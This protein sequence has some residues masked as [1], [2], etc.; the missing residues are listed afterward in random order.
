MA[1]PTGGMRD[2]PPPLPPDVAS[3]MGQ[4]PSAQVAQMVS[5]G[6]LAANPQGAIL[7][8]GQAVEKVLRDM[9]RTQPKFGPFADR[10]VAVLKAGLGELTGP[11][12]TA[13]QP[14]PMAVPGGQSLRPP[15]AEGAG[16]F[17]G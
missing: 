12:S 2:M 6:A 11:D 3:Q 15:S 13:S 5:H 8:Q 7:A 16:D 10:M 9:A 4:P 1:G 14:A 17:I